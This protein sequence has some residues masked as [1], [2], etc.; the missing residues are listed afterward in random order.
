MPG[1]KFL[2][3]NDTDITET[4]WFVLI[5]TVSGESGGTIIGDKWILTC[6]H[7]ISD[8]GPAILI[9]AGYDNTRQLS[10]GEQRRDVRRVFMHPDFDPNLVQSSDNQYSDLALIELTDSFQFT[11]YVKSI[12]YSGEEINLV[13]MPMQVLIAGMGFNENNEFPEQLQSRMVSMNT[14]EAGGKVLDAEL[15]NFNQGDSGGGGVSWM[16]LD[17]QYH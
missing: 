16:L 11:D 17:R 15:G 14:I 10:G 12:P 6:A 5:G 7:T 9:L 1:P 2:M 4:P 3:A 8:V 13:D